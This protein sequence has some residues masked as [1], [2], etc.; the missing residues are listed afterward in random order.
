V[1][2]NALAGY[3]RDPRA[4]YTSE[5]L[6]WFEHG[7]ERVLGIVICDRTDRDFA[8]VVLGRDRRG[9]FRAVALTP[10]EQSRR[11]AEAQLRREMERL[12]LAPDKEYYQGDEVGSPPDFF[13]P[14]AAPERWHPG[15]LKLAGDEGFSPARGIIEPMMHWYEDP[16]G[17]FIE[18]FQTTGFDARLWELYLFA[19]FIEIGYRIDRTYTAPDFV[20]VG[21]P[22]EFAV[23]AMTVNPTRDKT[24]TIVPPPPRDTPENRRR[25]LRDYM[26]MKFGSTLTSKLAKSYWEKPSVS[27]KPLLFAIQDFSAPA[28]MVFS[29][30]ALPVYLYGHDYDWERD[31]KGGL[32]ISPQQ[33]AAHRWGEKEIPSGFFNLPGAENVSAVVFSSSGTI[34][35]FNRMGVLAGFGSRRVVLVR[36]GYAIDHDPD[37][38]EP[39]TFCSL[40]NVPGYSETW[41]E[42]LDV[43]HN[44]RANHPIEPW[45]L[46]GAGHHRFRSDGQM[47]SHTP[48]WHPLS[49]ITNVLVWDDEQEARRAVAE[50]V[51]GESPP[52]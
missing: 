22:G 43:F 1:R 40:V 6:A 42:G 30:S 39:R 11:R 45:M 20:C 32:Q 50:W 21:V 49:S 34:S 2:F 31:S 14:H 8:G 47:V 36:K 51:T 4:R 10:F 24:G 44:P 26:P 25:F 18:Q 29:R 46:P 13:A 17:N 5:E 12:S 41:V 15:F 28:S 3:C 48:D 27:G 9:R 33:I 19:T 38:A 35:K 23:E 7:G 37:A 16:D 52:P